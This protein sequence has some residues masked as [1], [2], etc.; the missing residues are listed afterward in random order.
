MSRDC[1]GNGIW[2]EKRD[3]E[4][5]QNHADT[6]TKTVWKLCGAVLLRWDNANTLIINGFYGSGGGI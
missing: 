5:S 4:M 2:A 1:L 6:K 3:A